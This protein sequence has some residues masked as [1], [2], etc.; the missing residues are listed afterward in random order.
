MLHPCSWRDDTSVERCCQ[1]ATVFTFFRRRHHCRHCGGVFCGV[2]SGQRLWLRPWPGAAAPAAPVAF[3]SRPAGGES[4]SAANS[5]R[6]TGSGAGV[7]APLAS[8]DTH[9]PGQAHPSPFPSDSLGS[10]AASSGSRAPSAVSAATVVTPASVTL[11]TAARAEARREP[12]SSPTVDAIQLSPAQAASAQTGVSAADVSLGGSH[13]DSKCDG[14]ATMEHHRTDADAVEGSCGSAVGLTSSSTE[15]ESRADGSQAPAQDMD[16]G[17]PSLSPPASTSTLPIMP[18]QP[19][20]SD[21]AGC[22]ANASAAAAAATNFASA[23]F[24]GV[25]DSRHGSEAL[26]TPCTYAV[27]PT[28]V[29]GDVTPQIWSTPLAASGLEYL[30]SIAQCWTRAARPSPGSDEATLESLPQDRSDLQPGVVHTD[31]N[32]PPRSDATTSTSGISHADAVAYASA[33]YH[34]E[35]DQRSITWYLCRVCRGCYNDLSDTILA[36]DEHDPFLSQQQQQQRQRQPPHDPSAADSAAAITVPPLWQYVRLSSSSRIRRTRSDRHVPQQHERYHQQVPE[37]RSVTATA[38][39]SSPSTSM[40]LPLSSTWARLHACVSL[41]PSPVTLAVQL[42]TVSASTAAA[43]TAAAEGPNDNAS[44]VPPPP[45][46]LN[47]HDLLRSRDSPSIMHVQPLVQRVTTAALRGQRTAP[48][49]SGVPGLPARP[50]GPSTVTAD[51]SRFSSPASAGHACDVSAMSGSSASLQ[52]LSRQSTELASPSRPPHQQRPQQQQQQRIT[53]AGIVTPPRRRL[54][55]IGNSAGHVRQAVAIAR[56]RR[57]IAVILIDEREPVE[58]DGAF[59][60]DRAGFARASRDCSASGE[61][62]GAPPPQQ[63]QQQPQLTPGTDNSS[64]AG[65]TSP[66]GSPLYTNTAAVGFDNVNDSEAKQRRRM[67]PSALIATHTG[68]ALAVAANSLHTLGGQS[69]LT[70]SLTTEGREAQRSNRNDAAHLKASDASRRLHLSIVVDLEEDNE[71]ALIQGQENEVLRGLPPGDWLLPALPPEAAAPG[72]N[73]LHTNNNSLCTTVSA[74]DR[75]NDTAALNAAPSRTSHARES[76]SILTDPALATP[77]RPIACAGGSTTDDGAGAAATPKHTSFSAATTAASHDH[78]SSAAVVLPESGACVLNALFRE[79]GAV[80]HPYT[81][82]VTPVLNAPTPTFSAAAAASGT[83]L[84]SPLSSNGASKTFFMDPMLTGVVPQAGWGTGPRSYAAQRQALVRD[85]LLRQQRAIAAA[86][87]ASNATT[88]GVPPSA[89]THTWSNASMGN[90]LT[91]GS[92]FSAAAATPRVGGLPTTPPHERVTAPVNV[93]FQLRSPTEDAVF[94]PTAAST[95]AAATSASTTPPL[96]ISILP[97]TTQIEMIG[98][99]IDVSATSPH[100]ALK[101]VPTSASNFAASRNIPAGGSSAA[102][103]SNSQGVA[104]AT[105]PFTFSEF[106]PQLAKLSTNLD[107]YL[108]VV[109][110]CGSRGGSGAATSASPTLN[111]T[112]MDDIAQFSA[113]RRARRGSMSGALPSEM[114][115]LSLFPALSCEGDA[116]A[117]SG[118][119]GEESSVNSGSAS[120]TFGNPNSPIAPS[121]AT[122]TA[123]TARGRPHEKSVNAREPSCGCRRAR[124]ADPF[125]GPPLRLL[126]QQLQSCGVTQPAL[127]V[128]DVCEDLTFNDVEQS[129]GSAFSCGSPVRECIGFPHDTFMN[130]NVNNT[131]LLNKSVATA[132]A[133]TTTSPVDTSQE[134]PSSPLSA[135]FPVSSSSAFLLVPA[136]QRAVALVGDSTSK[137]E[138]GEQ[139]DK[140]MLPCSLQDTRERHGSADFT[141]PTITRNSRN[142]YNDSANKHELRRLAAQEHAMS[143]LR[144]AAHQLG[145][146]YSSMVYP[147]RG[148]TAA[149]STGTGGGDGSG[150]PAEPP[151]RSSRV[152]GVAA[153]GEKSSCSSCGGNCSGSINSSAVGNAL[154]SRGLESLMATMVHRDLTAQQ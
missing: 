116:H 74:A 52:Q 22:A 143:S 67:N 87:A 145:L 86:A 49:L 46:V 154:L 89:G 73:P 27:S 12:S 153:A 128:V 55:S 9:T 25:S 96:S 40:K 79:L 104:G 132:A 71:A 126:Y 69:T 59:F 93:F 47:P 39:P 70:E 136:L 33:S 37:S 112:A 135:V 94:M 58:A 88:S 45:P 56:R 82:P 122:T 60:G 137:P 148:G 38:P 62:R 107:G 51:G 110:R 134:S 102:A 152:P 125:G 81:T 121:V 119:L 13:G 26:F 11:H 83:C 108:V 68:A 140:F 2:C 139:P 141:P 91:S 21:A 111:A 17:S 14:V 29:A 133:A 142:T 84:F 3:S 109:L 66:Y 16:E 76:L 7:R 130:S 4:I 117:N 1:C 105:R 41:P 57:R 115:G 6:G 127:S 61:R 36:A 123:T 118:R 42:A 19:T 106:L 100:P 120:Y 64:A 48:P 99:P 24:S 138:R 78:V 75:V 15:A 151:L 34:V 44:V 97:V 92:T 54:I 10:G 35:V 103:F 20:L 72:S 53:R 28:A 101:T 85:M 98:I 80:T 30:S 113:N 144:T 147:T 124:V 50:Y 95:A 131:S 5:K 65:A 18:T 150:F 90:V 77:S 31:N 129:P 43:A 23:V 8:A 146:P 149:Q 114:T 32:P 63:Q